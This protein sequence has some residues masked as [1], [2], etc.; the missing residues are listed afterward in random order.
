MNYSKWSAA[1]CCGDAPEAL[2]AAG[3]PPLLASMLAVRGIETEERAREFLDGDSDCL[4]DPM[5]FKGMDKA[6]SRIKSALGAGETFAVYGDYDVDGITATCLL[7]D[8]LRSKGAEC[9]TYIPDRIAEGYGLNCAAIDKLKAQGVSLI[10][11]V[12]CGITAAA[13]AKHAKEIGVDIIITDHHECREETLPS[14][15]AVIDAKQPDCPYPNK[16]LAGVGVALKLV[17]AVEGESAPVIERY[18][19]LAA[20]GTLADVVP[21]VGENRYIVRCGIDAM[22]HRPRPGIAALLRESGAGDKRI[23][24]TTI[25]FSLAPRLNAAGRLGCVPVALK[26]LMT[27]DPAEASSLASV[28]CDLNRR[29]QMLEMSIWEDAK[30]MMSRK[31]PGL[32]I[33]LSSEKWHQGVIGIA[34][35]KLAEQYSVPTVMIC[36]DGEKGKGS[37][38]S[39]GGFNLFDALSACSEYLESFGGH[40]LA[41]GLNIRRERLDDFCRAFEEYYEKNKPLELPELCC[42]LEITEPESLDMEGVE[43]LS[44]LEP[45]GNGNAKPLMCI[46]GCRL[47]RI[48]EIGGGRHLRL[49]VSY[50]GKSFECVFFSHSERDLNVGVG[51]CIDI[52]FTPQ[53]N[54]FRQNRTVQLQIT[55]VRRH[56][57]RELCRSL[58]SGGD[59]FALRRA[60]VYCPDRSDFV[61]AWRRLQSLGGTVAEDFEN[62][63][64]QCPV[65]LRPESFCICLCVLLELGLMRRG[66]SGG[67]LGADII[68]DSAKVN[69]E[70]SRII[71]RLRRENGRRQK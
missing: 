28:L 47:D 61:K 23:T 19:E 69:L 27:K 36:L 42:D 51:D 70:D 1:R 32:P 24:A 30:G 64:R 54:E 67:I 31:S 9:L 49:G 39:C 10:I 11:S 58:L 25:V 52:A 63:L 41:A 59:A 44:R 13:E 50:R 37:C 15:V 17:C 22:E 40:A 62:V 43:A 26:L 45:F 66:S 33:V 5:L 46:L 21:L 53:I 3:Y 12:D 55:A 6:V 4:R 16:E 35:S 18:A 60:A 20:V 14:A 2:L 57:P 71:K 29:R 68:R 7:S 65:G 34:A 56:D 48:N 8:W 38:R